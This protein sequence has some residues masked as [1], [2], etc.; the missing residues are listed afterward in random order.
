[1]PEQSDSFHSGEFSGRIVR[2]NTTITKMKSFASIEERAPNSSFSFL[3]KFLLG[4]FDFIGVLES[5]RQ[6]CPDPD[7]KAET[8]AV[9]GRIQL[10]MSTL[11]KIILT[12]L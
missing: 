10:L 12:S 3:S 1:M 5:M 9:P 8:G 7:A 11:L 6:F 2:A 4:G